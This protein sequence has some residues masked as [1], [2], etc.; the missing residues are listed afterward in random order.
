[1][2]FGTIQQT[3]STRSSTTKLTSVVYQRT[4]ISIIWAACSPF[5]TRSTVSISTLY[6]MSVVTKVEIIFALRG[7]H[8]CS[9]Q[10][11]VILQSTVQCFNIWQSIKLMDLWFKL[12]FLNMPANTSLS[13]YTSCLPATP[14]GSKATAK[15]WV[16]LACWKLEVCLLHL[17]CGSKPTCQKRAETTTSWHM[18]ESNSH[19]NP[20]KCLITTN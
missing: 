16:H 15:A 14:L 9:I 6:F 10:H 8:R 13:I 12:D 1:M 7:F 3:C 4:E 18:P 20:N 17:I 5:N 19:L 2:P 11:W